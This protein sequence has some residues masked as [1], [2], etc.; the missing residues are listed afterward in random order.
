MKP[1]AST[2]STIHPRA[3]SEEDAARY[4]GIS[5]S[6]LRKGRMAGRRHAQMSSPPFVKM[7]R[8]V[9]YLIDDL[10]SWITKNR[11]AEQRGL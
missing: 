1:S 11:I 5:Q 9:V 2:T 6:S 3:V 4:L 7:G 10:D 8:R